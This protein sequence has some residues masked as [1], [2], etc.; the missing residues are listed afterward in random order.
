MVADKL[1]NLERL[2]MA[3]L[4]MDYRE[5]GPNISFPSL[6]MLL[7]CAWVSDQKWDVPRLVRLGLPDT[8]FG[9]EAPI[10]CTFS[11]STRH[12]VITLWGESS[13]QFALLCEVG[14]TLSSVNERQG[15]LHA[16]ML[17]NLDDLPTRLR[18]AFASQSTSLPSLEPHSLSRV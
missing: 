14:L 2:N 13:A 9:T 17:G 6:H 7:M 15:L 11:E 1:P 5:G 16:N 8:E 18:A 4:V 10:L 12:G 3:G